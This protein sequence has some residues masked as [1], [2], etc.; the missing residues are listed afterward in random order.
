MDSSRELMTN[1]L[2]F[3]RISRLPVSLHWWGIYK[4]ESAGLDFKRDAWQEGSKISEVYIKFYEKFSPDWFHLHIGTPKYFKDS[5]IVKKDGRNMLSI[6]DR[7]RGLKKEDKYFSCGSG[8]DEEIMDFPDYLLSSRAKKPKADLSSKKKI[9]DYVDKY[10]HLTSKEI[11]ELGYTDH[12]GEIHKK[13]NKDAFLAVHIPSAICEIF[14]P[15]TGYMGFEEGL[16]AFH[17]YPEGMQYFLERCYIEQLEWARA[18]ADNGADA[19]IIS[20]SYI[21]PD[22]ASPDIYRRF[23]KHIHKDYFK[24]IS[25]YGIEPLCMFWG[26]INPLIDDYCDVNLK[27]MLIEESKKG[28]ELD[29]VKIRRKTEGK[30]CLFGNLDSLNLLNSGSHENI[31]SEALRQSDGLDTGFIISNGSPITPGTPAENVKALIN[32]KKEF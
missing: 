29:V 12:L 16:L 21:S 19:F 4:Y 30:V 3:K 24:E 7:Y 31:R 13:Y 6:A 26:N 32:F 1:C 14:D 8:L 5:E 9:D 25:G 23:M 15:T 22:L 28:F 27:G 20:E 11:T 2:N 10:I 18:Y 17:D